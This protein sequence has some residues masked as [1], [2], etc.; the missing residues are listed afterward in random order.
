MEQYITDLSTAAKELYDQGLYREALNNYE[1]LVTAQV[2][3]TELFYN[4]GNCFTRLGEYGEAKLY[5]ERALVFD[6]SN[7]DALH[8]LDWINLRLA[9]ALIEPNQELIEWLSELFRGVLSEEAWMVLGSCVLLSSFLLLLWRRFSNRKINWRIP[10]TATLIG[11]A[12]VAI[13]AISRPKIAK[14][15]VVDTSSYGYS[16]PSN[17]GKRIILLSEGSAGNVTRSQGAWSLMVLGDGR[18]AW[19]ESEQWERV[20]PEDPLK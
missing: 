4:M 13:S 18:S 11:I 19:F 2:K 20:Y 8:N 14:C 1:Q 9:D 3:D 17:S 10:F 6:P 12:L 5:F 15:I 16:E 7:A